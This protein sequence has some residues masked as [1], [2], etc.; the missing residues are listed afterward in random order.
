MGSVNQTQVLKLTRQALYWPS[1]SRPQSTWTAHMQSAALA[2]SLSCGYQC[3]P[4][5]LECPHPGKHSL[6]SAGF[7]YTLITGSIFCVFYLN[8]NH[9]TNTHYTNSY[10]HFWQPIN[11][12]RIYMYFILT[13]WYF[14]HSLYLIRIAPTECYEIT[15]IKGRTS[16][17]TLAV[18]TKHDFPSANS[19]RI[20]CHQKHNAK[21]IA[22]HS[23]RSV[24]WP[25]VPRPG[26]PG[27]TIS[28]SLYKRWV[29]T[30]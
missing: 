26:G 7:L 3:S 1:P 15:P 8:F 12:R 9:V 25:S 11:L 28:S 22:G 19:R 20:W 29:N 14:Y 18:P 16:N 5:A 21:V 6:G 2:E 4:L 23:S 24:T 13:K 17:C 27:Q 30:G 10:S